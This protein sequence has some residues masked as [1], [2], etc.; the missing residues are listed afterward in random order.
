MLSQEYFSTKTRPAHGKAG[1]I[2]GFLGRHV[3]KLAFA[4]GFGFLVFG[5]GVAVGKLRIAPHDTI[6]A[7][8]EAARDWQENWRHYLGVRS[9]WVQPTTRGGGVTIHDPRRAWPGQTFITL[10]RAGAWGAVLVD[11]E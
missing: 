11:M 2:L 4:L 10:Y 1:A 9:K 5:Y 8:V 6:S 7:A 3:D